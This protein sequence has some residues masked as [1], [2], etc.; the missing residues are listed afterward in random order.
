MESDGLDDEMK[1][2]LAT[3]CV[4]C[5]ELLYIVAEDS[6]FMKWQEGMAVQDA[7]PYLSASDREILFSRTCE[8]C[9]DE[10]FGDWE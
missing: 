1:T 6:D 8:K 4:R 10:M 5:D 7:F 9:W 3:T 2:E